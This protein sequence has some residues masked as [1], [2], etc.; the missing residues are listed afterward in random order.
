MAEAATNVH[1]REG[2]ITTS[3]Q[4]KVFRFGLGKFCMLPK[5]GL[6]LSEVFMKRLYA[7]RE[8]RCPSVHPRNACKGHVHKDVCV[9]LSSLNTTLGVYYP[10]TFKAGLW[11]Y[12]RID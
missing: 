2:G 9:N 5:D 1:C 7:K 11:S 12:L 4:W 3:L 8:K 6:D 10:T